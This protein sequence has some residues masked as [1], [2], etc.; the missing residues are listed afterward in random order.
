M[1]RRS[2]SSSSPAFQ[3]MFAAITP[4]LIT[5]AFAERKR[6][7]RVRPLHDPLVD[8]RLLAARPLGLGGRWLALQARRAR[9]RRRHG[10]PRQLRRV[11]PARRAPHRQARTS[12]ATED[13][14]ARHPDDRPRR[15]P[16]V[17]R[18]V[19]LQRRLRGGRRWPGRERAARHEHGRRRRD[20]HLG[21]R[22]LL[23]QAQGQRR[24]RRV[25]RR[26]WP[27]RDHPGIRAS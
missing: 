1:R 22:E 6:F 2:R 10:R 4:A 24:R 26:R 17:V 21:P 7:A 19:R 9:L 13:G 5:G 27:R 16:P 18:L 14:A 11:G 23:P 20:H 8:L 25:R 15:R 12:T 3:L